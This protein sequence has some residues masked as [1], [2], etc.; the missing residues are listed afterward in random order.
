MRRVRQAIPIVI[1]VLALSGCGSKEASKP[2][3]GQPRAPKAKSTPSGQTVRLAVGVSPSKAGGPTKVRYHAVIGTRSGVKPTAVNQ[4]TFRAQQGFKLNAGE[5]P[6]CKVGDLKAGR[7]KS[8][9]KAKIGEGAAQVIP[10]KGGV[11]NSRIT[12]FNGGA[13]GSDVTFLYYVQ[14]PGYKPLAAAATVAKQAGGQWGY[15]ITYPPITTALPLSKLDLTTLDKTVKSG[16]RTLHLIEA[17]ASCKRS[18]RF[19]STATFRSGEKLTIPAAA[20]CSS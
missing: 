2:V 19:D 16:G 5:F 11:L 8:C 20:A 10:P 7:V 12:T 15:S 14:T 17:P 4:I 1:G 3:S 6:S 13:H 9:S 18:W